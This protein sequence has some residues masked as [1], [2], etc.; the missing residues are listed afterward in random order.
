ML[1]WETAIGSPIR[2]AK[3]SSSVPRRK[4]A[5]PCKKRSS[6][7]RLGTVSKDPPRHDPCN[8]VSH[9]C[10]LSDDP[11]VMINQLRAR[12]AEMEAD[13]KK[14]TRSL[15]VPSPD[16]PGVTR[17]CGAGARSPVRPH[18]DSHRPGKFSCP[19]VESLQPIVKTLHFRVVKSRY[20]PARSTRG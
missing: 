13:R 15:S 18:A 2:S 14:R 7:R 12:V 20:G 3:H 1:W 11:A 6:G 5:S 16:M 17:P 9:S 19:E 4:N 8:R 10:H